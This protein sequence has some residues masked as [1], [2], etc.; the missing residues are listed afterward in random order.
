MDRLFFILGCISA[1]ISVAAGAFGSHALR[2]RLTPDFLNAFEVGVKYQM[3]HALGLL[4]VA[5]AVSHWPNSN[6]SVTGWLF[7]AGTVFF[8]GSLYAM[9]LTGVRGFGAITPIGGLL[10]ILGWLYLAWTIFQ[11]RG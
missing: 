10:F 9:S 1:F 7:I 3:Y 8:S 11:A 4:A 6:A 5:W 2:E